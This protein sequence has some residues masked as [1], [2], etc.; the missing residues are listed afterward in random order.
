MSLVQK[1]AGL[2]AIITNPSRITRLILSW[3]SCFLRI[4]FL[5][6]FNE[7]DMVTIATWMRAAIDN[8]DQPAELAKLRKE[9][10]KFALQFPLPSD[11]KD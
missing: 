7:D 1:M 10:T 5:S 8:H 11:R 4:S 9:V 6:K 3:G 2:V